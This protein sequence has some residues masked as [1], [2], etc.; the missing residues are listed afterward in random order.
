[1]TTALAKPSVQHPAPV[2]KPSALSVMASRVN[3][4]PAK[5]MA[6]LRSTCFKGAN[7]EEMLALVVVANEYNQNPFLKEIY[8]CPKKGGG[9]V[10]VVGVDG[11]VKM[12]NR[13]DAFDGVEFE[14]VDDA[15]NKPHSCTCTL[16][17]KN[18]T[19]PVKVTEYFDECHRNTDP[20]NQM[21]RRMLRHKAL[22]QCARVAFGFSGVTDED[23]AHS[24]A[25][26]IVNVESFQAEGAK[27]V[28]LPPQITAPA[29]TAG[30][31]AGITTPQ[32]QLS[33]IVVSAG[34]T[35]T[36]FATWADAGGHLADA[37]SLPGFDAVP[38]DVA[39]RLIKAK[40]GML[41]GIGDLKGAAQ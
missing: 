32:Q 28:D 1:M 9:I 36:D 18:R 15:E 31:S 2:A 26:T 41:R 21:P 35:F 5:L 34:F 38:A 7:D 20:W 37:T 3:V 13:A 16:Y 25:G 29:P 12:V 23:E 4:D 11:W 17:L 19:R 8:A 33:D 6:T 30:Q 40:T 24:V 22:M 39:S 27:V 10:P 14:M